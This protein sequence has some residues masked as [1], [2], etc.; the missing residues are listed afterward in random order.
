MMTLKLWLTIAWSFVK[1]QVCLYMYC[2]IPEVMEACEKQKQRGGV[3]VAQRSADGTF[4]L[5]AASWT[6]NY[7]LLLEYFCRLKDWISNLR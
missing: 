2:Y 3:F 4:T 7:T 6:V 1:G 5:L